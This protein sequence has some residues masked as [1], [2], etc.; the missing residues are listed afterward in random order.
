MPDLKELPLISR[1]RAHG[2]RAAIHSDGVVSRYDDLLR[3]SAGMA[4]ALLG[5]SPD[6]AEARIAFMAPA[7][8]D[9]FAIQWAIW[10]AGGVAVPLSSSATEPELEHVLTD[11]RADRVVAVA[12]HA[13]KLAALCGR[14]GL[15]LLP[16][17]G[18]GSGELP[19]IDPAR[20]AM[21]LYT[22]GTTSK[23]K[24]VVTTHA[25]IGA[26]IESLVSAWEWSAGDR[27]PLFLPMHHVHGIINIAA[28]ALW[29]GALVETFA[30]FDTAAVLKR[31]A[32]GAYTVFM[33][34]PTIYVK[35]IE[36]L[37]SDDFSGDFGKEIR[38]G[39]AGMRLMVSGSAALPPSIH[40]KWH[41][42]T[43]QSL[44]ER[45]GMTET[46]M[47]ISNPYRGE[48]RQGAVGLPLPGVTIRLKSESGEVIT[49]ENEPGEIQAKG[50]SIFHEY[51]NRPEVTTESFDEGWF[52]TG[53]M[54]VVEDGY[55][56]IMGRLSSDI[57]KSGGYKLS[58][59]EIEAA[60]LEHPLIRECAVVGVKDDTWGEA[61]AVAAA[62]EDGAGGL[63][64]GELRRWGKERLS[65][66]KLPTRMLVVDQLPRNAMGKVT[67][68]AVGKWIDA[69]QTA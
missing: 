21:I 27:I 18:S 54:A 36:A 19:E 41:A 23:P 28:C 8:F 30:K 33:A 49:A 11:S 66:Y 55:Y 58:A 64:L 59:L 13:G 6:L 57:I 25:T 34:V 26:Q 65:P 44:L 50:P 10:R 47:M 7:G 12:R 46:G 45:Y 17:A 53:D 68:A 39:F 22:S 40:E 69:S 4:K 24:G 56:R 51:W 5:E 31:V 43:G 60:L 62:L 52:R 29:S 61:V 32:A 38:A 2:N 14:L 16:P 48:R 15:P 67:K 20:R 35:L 3:A 63:D 42:L 9:Y 1:A 37:G